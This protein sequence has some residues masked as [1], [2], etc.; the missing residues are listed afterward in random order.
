MSDVISMLAFA[1]LVWGPGFSVAVLGSGTTDL[2]IKKEIDSC[3]AHS[4]V[5]KRTWGTVLWILF[6][7]LNRW[8]VS[9]LG[10]FILLVLKLG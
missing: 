3:R 1:M 8:L 9:V 10:L 5:W 4:G 2:A 7:P 6:D